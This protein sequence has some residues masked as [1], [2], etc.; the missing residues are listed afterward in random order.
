M[1]MKDELFPLGRQKKTKHPCSMSNNWRRSLTSGEKNNMEGRSEI[2]K[3]NK[4][5]QLRKKKKRKKKKEIREKKRILC[6]EY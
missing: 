2:E 4:R 5:M 1:L 6:F 3:A